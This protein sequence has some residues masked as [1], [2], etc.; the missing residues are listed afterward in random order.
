MPTTFTPL[1]GAPELAS[2]QAQKEEKHNEALRILE[3]FATRS[4]VLDRDLSAAPGSPSDGDRYLVKATPAGGD[5]WE[6]HTGEIAIFVN[7]AWIFVP[8]FEGLEIEVVDEDAAFVRRGGSWIAIGGG[9]GGVQSVP[10]MAAA[11]TARTTNGAAIGTAELTTNKIMLA[12]L[13]FDQSTI[14]YAQFMFP[15]PK[16]W[17]EGT[18]TAQ[19][20]WTASSGSGDV[21]FGIQAVALSNDDA[22]D[23]AFGTAQEVT[24]TLLSANDQHTTAFTS[25]VTIGGTPAEGDLVVFQVYRKASAGGDTIA[26]DVKLLGIRL[27]YTT[28]AADDS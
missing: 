12:A 25:A 23:T 24:D 18:V 5:A 22:L 8:V 27:N 13:D 1:L 19:F 28:N 15:M 11:M 16:S 4:I 6:G 26:A 7:T 20:I 2:S 17:D 10:I 14:E 9:G 21:I 3:A